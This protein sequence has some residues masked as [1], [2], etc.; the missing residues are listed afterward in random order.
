MRVRDY[1]DESVTFGNQ[2]PLF[3]HMIIAEKP[4]W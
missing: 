4:E 1:S 3:L 2:N